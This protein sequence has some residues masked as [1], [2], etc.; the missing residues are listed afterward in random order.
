MKEKRIIITIGQLLLL[1]IFSLPSLTALNT[2]NS[3]AELNFEDNSSLLENSSEEDYFYASASWYGAM[4]HGRKMANGQIFDM[5]NEHIVA[6]KTLPF[7]TKLEIINPKNDITLYAVV[8][9][10]GPYI[11]GRDFDLS[12]AGAEK[13]DIIDKGVEEL[14]IRIIE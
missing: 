7:G 3:S 11:Q 14:K 10:R 4:F 5:Y 9:D 6:H 12:Y 8:E 1:G 2:L 13:L